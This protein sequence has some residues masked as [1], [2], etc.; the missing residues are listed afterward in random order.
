VSRPLKVTA[1]GSAIVDVLAIVDDR[2]LLAHNVAKGVM[3]LVDEHRAQTL[4]A[5]LPSPR[6]IAGGSAANTMAGLAS[7][8]ATGAF[9]GKVKRD[10]LGEIFASDMSAIG[11]RYRTK[12]AEGGPATGCCLIAVTPEGE[13]SMSTY[14]GANLEFSV[15]DLDAQD[16]QDADVLYIE[17]YLWDAPLAREACLKAIEIAKHSGTKVAFTISDPFVAG[18]YREDFLEMLSG[19]NFDILFANEEEAKSLFEVDE[20]DQVFQR[21]HDWGGI[22]ALTRS[23]KGC[24]IACDGDVHVIDAAPVDRVVDTTGAGDQFAAGFLF[25]LTHGKPLQDCGKLGAIAAAEVISHL[26]ARPKTSLKTV[27]AKAGLL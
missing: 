22:G 1:I 8:G 13:R 25:G 5:A 12:K 4:H 18:R 17:G 27:A 21:V 16:I 3:T 6:E 7:L 19:R 9:L 20:F 11:L 26:G 23:E 2:F 15:G 10:R 24:V 14:L